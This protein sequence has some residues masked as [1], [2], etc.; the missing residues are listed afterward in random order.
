MRAANC[1]VVVGFLVAV[2]FIQSTP[3]AA[4]YSA[5][6]EIAPGEATP[7]EAV[8]EAGADNAPWRLGLLRLS[9]WL[10]VRNASW[11]TNTDESGAEERDFTLSFGAGL[12]GYI[13][14]GPKVT[15][16]A[17]LLPEYSWWSE[18]TEKRRLNGRYGLG[19]FGFFNRLHVELSARRVEEQNYFTSEIQEL[20]SSSNDIGRVA[21]EVRVARR[22]W[23]F[24]NLTHTK[25]ENQ[26]E[27]TEIFDLLNREQ[28][29]VN[30]GFRL[31]SPRGWAVALGVEQVDNKFDGEARNLSNSGTS[32]FLEGSFLGQRFESRLRV[33][34][35]SIDPDPGSEFVPFDETTGF[36]ELLW[37]RSDRL[38]FLAYGRRSL[39]Y[40]VSNVNSYFLSDRQGLRVDLGIRRA[41]LSFSTE[42]GEDEFAS[43]GSQSSPRVDDV[44]AFGGSIYLPLGRKFGISLI[45]SRTEYDSSQIGAE[46]ENS[47]FGLT[48]SYGRLRERLELGRRGDVW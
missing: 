24:G 31:R 46:R 23:L 1:L 21:L 6:G 48:L 5:P 17:H 16:A 35:E 37:T 40:S 10:G 3:L 33:A 9:P 2:F 4:Q 15:W 7:N 29:V 14:N 34:F 47:S 18:T 28:D 36:L 32:P 44:T 19:F 12:R 38:Q 27:D 45:G 43:F 41:N 30:A 11:V 42:T 25:I 22:L 8:L 26:E 13:R 39:V 20:T